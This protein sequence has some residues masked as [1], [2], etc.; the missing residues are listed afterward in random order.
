MITY[1]TLWLPVHKNSRFQT[2]FHRKS[3]NCQ[4]IIQSFEK[5]VNRREVNKKCYVVIHKVGSCL[6][7]DAHCCCRRKGIQRWRGAEMGLVSSCQLPYGPVPRYVHHLWYSYF[8]VFICLF[9]YTTKTTYLNRV[10]GHHNVNR[11]CSV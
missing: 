6:P 7:T 2:R 4:T 5:S 9:G 1:L 8:L 11:R 10:P 3:P